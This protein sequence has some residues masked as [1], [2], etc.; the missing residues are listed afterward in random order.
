M[1]AEVD[2][3]CGEWQDRSQEQEPAE[4]EESWT[5]RWIEGGLASCARWT[6]PSA[7]AR[8][9]RFDLSR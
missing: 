9:L 7:V 4:P 3:G 2:R 8:D 1:A 5:R 6:N